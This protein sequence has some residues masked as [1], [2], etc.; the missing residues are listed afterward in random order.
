MCMY[1]NSE[2][3]YKR[4]AKEDIVCYKSVKNSNDEETVR[5]VY[6]FFKYRIGRTYRKRKVVK[7]KRS[8]VYLPNAFRVDNGFFHSYKYLGPAKVDTYRF[9]DRL[10]VQCIIPKGS[11][12]YE[13][14]DI[15]NEECYC[16]TAIRI[17]KAINEKVSNSFNDIL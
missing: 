16:S 10:V 11:K 9:P 6:Y 1:I 4:T 7:P 3:F 15:S 14:K 17:V 13:G 5:A 2:R 12:Y 8:R